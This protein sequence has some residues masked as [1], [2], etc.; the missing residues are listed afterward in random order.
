V[1]GV[2][3]NVK[4]EIIGPVLNVKVGQQT[5]NLEIAHAEKRVLF[6]SDAIPFWYPM[7]GIEYGQ[8]D[9]FEKIG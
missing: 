2:G 4:H 3:Y 6:T 5:C 1:K 8:A 7:I 9:Q